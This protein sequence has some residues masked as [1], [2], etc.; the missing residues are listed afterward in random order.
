MNGPVG[1][2]APLSSAES[3]LSTSLGIDRAHAQAFTFTFDGRSLTAYEGETIGAALHAAGQRVISRSFKYHR[4]RGLLCV[5]G[6]CPNC[7]V[8][9]DGV[10]NVRACCTPVER[11]ME[12]RSQ[13][14]WP[15]LERDAMAVVDRFDRLLPVGF[16]Y[17]TMHRPRAAWPLAERVLRHAAGLGVLDLENERGQHYEKETRYCDLAVVGGGPAGLSAALEAARLGAEVVLVDDQPAPGGHLRHDLRPGPDGVPGYRLAADL[18]AQAAAQPGLTI[19]TDATAFGLYEGNLLGIARG[20]RLIKLRARQIVVATG[21]FERPIPFHNNDLPGVM[22]GSGAQRLLHLYG[23]KPGRRTLVVSANDYG[24]EVAAD[25]LAAGIQVVG[26]VEARPKLDEGSEAVRRLREAAVPLLPGHTI[27]AALGRGA[28]EG[29]VVARLDHRGNAV[30]GSEWQVTCDTVALSV[31]FENAVGLLGQAGGRVGFDER[32]GEVVPRELPPDVLAAGD[33]AGHHGLEAVLVSGRLAGLRAAAALGLANAEASERIAGYE[34]ELVS[35]SAGDGEVGRRLVAV[36]G[37]GQ[38]RF[39]CFCEDI[40]EKDLCDGI[41]EGFDHLETLKRYSTLTMGPCQGRMCH[42][43]GVAICARE[44]GRTLAE[45]GLTTSRPPVTPVPLGMLAGSVEDPV[46]KSPMH[47]QHALLGATWT[48][49]GQWKRARDYG[50]P[51]AEVKAVREAVGIIDVSSLGKMELRGCDAGR[52]LDFLYT[53]RYADMPV[54]R[55]RYALM[56][57][58]A[59]IVVDDGAIGRPDEETF[60]L[61]TTTSGA[62]GVEEQLT[63]WAT[64]LG[65]QVYVT[66]LTSGMAAVNLAGPRARQ[67]LQPL[68]DVDI[69]R[70]ALPHLRTVRC[71]VAGIPALILRVGFVGEVGFEIHVP[72][73]YGA[74]LWDALMAAG[75]PHG[76]QPF[77]LEAQRIL[78]LEKGHIIINQDTD[79]LSNAIEAGL[80]WAIA[81]D[82][83]DFVG[84]RSLLEQRVRGP[85]NL[86]IGFQMRD[87]ALVPEEGSAIVELGKPVG[88]VTSAR[89]SPTLRQSIGMGWVPARLAQEGTELMIRVGGQ[90]HPAFVVKRPFYDQPGTRLRG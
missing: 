70:E 34:R 56:C 48:D 13:N 44:T 68:V 76:I 64:S 85:R 90:P 6:R 36:E 66:N 5:A 43:A 31:A 67:V 4:P 8:N 49:L 52:L 24:L 60:Y 25:L 23:V 19:L 11:G 71:K 75:K 3:R 46:R 14:A 21:R 88:R 73:D 15:S 41:A 40:T 29:A 80:G 58:D 72:A 83:P 79:A 10:P 87:A 69:S 7:L 33:V 18:A 12:V 82:K 27:T 55:L 38:K 30:A 61:T 50:S 17:K 74:A 9:V 81:W 35:H 86:L 77:G 20:S 63:W 65:W 2:R 57:D 16:Y 1:K 32:L 37:P 59:G 89:F 47:E 28:V 22:L 84:R 62:A 78:R 54:G 45:T 51:A 39:V 26:V 53:G 42:A